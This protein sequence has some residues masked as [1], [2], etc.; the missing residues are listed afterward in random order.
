MCIIVVQ[1]VPKCAK[2]YVTSGNRCAKR[3]IVQNIC[4][5]V[6]VTSGNRCAKRIICLKFVPKY[7]Y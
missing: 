5:K 1:V 7:D 4:A 2:V 6:Y 3:I